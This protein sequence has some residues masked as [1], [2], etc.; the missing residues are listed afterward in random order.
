MVAK[1]LHRRQQANKWAV[2]VPETSVDVE[3]DHWSPEEPVAVR[4]PLRPPWS[5]PL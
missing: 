4:S 5:I 1:F 2:K 3:S